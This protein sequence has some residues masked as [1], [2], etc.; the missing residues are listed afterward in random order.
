[1]SGQFVPF[2][3]L[4]STGASRVP[5]TRRPCVAQGALIYDL[6]HK[7]ASKD[8]RKISLSINSC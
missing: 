2:H 1:M 3:S 8:K 6:G 4:H 5:A 7:F